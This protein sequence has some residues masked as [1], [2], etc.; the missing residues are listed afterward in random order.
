MDDATARNC[1]HTELARTGF[2]PSATGSWLTMMSIAAPAVNPTTTE[3]G[4]RSTISPTRARPKSSCI[5]P[6]RKLKVSTR[7]M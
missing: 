5:A 7:R 6:T 4:T 2:K 3:C 1:S